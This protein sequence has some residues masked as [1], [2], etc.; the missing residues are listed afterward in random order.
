[1]KNNKF[2]S[3]GILVTLIFSGFLTTTLVG[4]FVSRDSISTQIAKTTLPLTSDTIYS[5]IQ[6][7]LLNPIFISSLM[8]QDT[9]VRDW[10]LSG[11]KDESAIIKYLKEIQARYNTVTCFFVSE[12]TH[13]YYHPTGML[14]TVNAADPRDAWYFRVEKMNTDY[15]INVDIDTANRNSLN[16]FINYRVYDYAHRFIGA[17]G[18]GLAVTSVRNMLNSYQNRY[19]RRVYFADRDGKI[20]LTSSKDSL[21]E[22]IRMIPGMDATATKILTSPGYSGTYVSA[23]NKVYINSRFVPEFGWYLLVEQKNDPGEVRIRSTLIVNIIISLTISL[24]VLFFANLTIGGYQR[25]LESLASTDKLTGVA[26]RQ[27]FDPV[28]DQMLKYTARRKEAFCVIMFDIDFFKQVNDTRG[29]LAGDEALKAVVSLVQVSIRESDLL[30]RWGGDEFLLLLPDCGM[31][32]AVLLAEKLRVAVEVLDISFRNDTFRVTCSF[33]VVEL[34]PGEPKDSLVQRSDNA[35]YFAKRDGRN[36]TAK[37][38]PTQTISTQG[39]S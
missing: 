31:D 3:I 13:R 36:R 6:R 10:T 4:Y 19:G 20:T 9:F 35:L 33:G 39:Q 1:M 24:I 15:E 18:V 16:I 29:H 37:G 27:S 28:F 12:R 38:L 23:G 25:R 14:K 22:S 11:E 2:R 34:A 32:K 7:D 8:A 5:E 17:T 21:P 30:C 26:N